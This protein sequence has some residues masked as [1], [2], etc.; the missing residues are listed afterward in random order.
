MPGS[1]AAGFSHHDGLKEKSEILVR[2]Q[3]RI[4]VQKD[5]IQSK[6]R[7]ELSLIDRWDCLQQSVYI[8]RALETISYRIGTR[9]KAQ[10][11]EKL[12]QSK[13]S[14]LTLRRLLAV[15]VRV[16]SKFRFRNRNDS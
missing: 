7:M 13:N 4:S 11:K 5:F 9:P 12:S 3:F 15:S 1:R 10:P 14:N 16:V 6:F 8:A 2:I